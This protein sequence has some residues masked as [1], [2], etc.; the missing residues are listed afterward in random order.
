M[1]GSVEVPNAED[2]SVTVKWTDTAISRAQ[3]EAAASKARKDLADVG[4]TEPGGRATGRG[5]S[6]V[7]CGTGCGDAVP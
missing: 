6:Q 7:S 5:G 2:P 1:C 4:L 3:R